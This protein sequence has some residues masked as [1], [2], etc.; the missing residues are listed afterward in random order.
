MVKRTSEKRT[1]GKSNGMCAIKKVIYKMVGH[2][3][4]PKSQNLHGIGRE[5][6]DH[7]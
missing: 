7:G 6:S 1:F 5:D 4:A 2:K 3:E